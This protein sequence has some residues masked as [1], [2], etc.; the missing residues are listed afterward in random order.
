MIPLSIRPSLLIEIACEADRM[1]DFVALRLVGE[2]LFLESKRW[3]NFQSFRA[4]MEK[5]DIE[6][7]SNQLIHVG[8]MGMGLEKEAA[9]CVSDDYSFCNHS[10]TVS[11][12]K[13]D[14]PSYPEMDVGCPQLILEG[15]VWNIT[16]HF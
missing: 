3:R 5:N 11:L 6:G 4:V 15:K 9:R 8:L 10:I 12:Q 13:T 16:D 7:I 1:G 14:L 2:T